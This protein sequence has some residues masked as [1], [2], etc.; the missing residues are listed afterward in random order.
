EATS[1]TSRRPSL[2]ATARDLPSGEA[3]MLA[4]RPTA[5]AAT[6][7]TPPPP[8]GALAD[9]ALA[10]P[11]LAW[12]VVP[13]PVLPWPVLAWPVLAWPVAAPSVPLLPFW[14]AAGPA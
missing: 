3:D 11:S 9:P 1:R 12:P 14:L 8:A 10:A 2:A 4:T 6:R 13:W 7:R 5:P